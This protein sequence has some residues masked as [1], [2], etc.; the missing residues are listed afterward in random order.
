MRRAVDARGPRVVVALC[1]AALL[2]AVPARAQ[3]PA[4]RTPS[5]T[6][7][8]DTASVTYRTQEVIFVS[9]GRAAGVAVGDTLQLLASD[10]HVAA[11]ALVLS[12]AQQSAS[13]TL[14][15]ADAAVGVGARVRLVH[16]P[17]VAVAAAGPAPAAPAPVE[18]PAPAPAA[19]APVAAAPP[20]QSESAAAAPAPA[21]YPAASS[22]TAFWPR[23]RWRANIQLD[24]SA[25]SAGG[26][27]SLTT[28][29]TAAAVGF[30]APLA[31]WLTMDARST[32]RWRNGSSELST[33]GLTGSNTI[34]Y[35]LEAR[36]APPGG[37]WN[38]S[39]GRFLSQ[40]APGLGYVDGAKLEV[41]PWSGQRIGVLAGYAPDPLTMS[42]STQMAQAGMYWG[43]TGPTFSG[44]LSGSTQWQWS[45]IR[46][47][48]FSAQS[49]WTPE[50]SLSFYLTTDVD[51]GA[52]WESFRGLRLTNLTL[53]F[54]TALPLGFRLNLSG[55]THQALE[56]FSMQV[57]GDT[58]ALPGRLTG[59]TA[60]L[61]HDVW[62]AAVDVTG[63]YLKQAT[64]P[65]PTYRGSLTIF[66]RHFMLVATGQH[67]S[68]FDFGSVM[69]RVPMPVIFSPLMLALGAG[70][71]VTSLPGGGQT[72][73]RYDLRP[74]VGLRLGGG[75]Y[76]SF[77]GDIGRYAGL[78]STYLQG[79]LAYQLW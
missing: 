66:S 61:G 59:L 64:D 30:T 32:T 46:R 9:A 25:N 14:I 19:P 18:A 58:F 43:T 48:W 77:N 47:T 44:S 22:Q 10:G 69:L 38:F 6:T 5:D 16:R 4:P 79:G 17:H 23:P 7:A 52:G 50:P 71:D 37:W 45:E 29:Q 73:W 68:L 8:R 36:V 15:P 39:L 3:Q 55:E 63:G 56:L 60:S 51:H 40:D 75:F 27:Q 12:V 20:A 72:F 42:P 34:V 54:R 35:Q 62:G 13:A 28:Y 21:A 11:R 70:A 74:E 65:A 24:Q 2:F 31:S 78:T 26:A 33:F 76:A 41:Q 49:Y 57:A 1:A 67:G 53:G